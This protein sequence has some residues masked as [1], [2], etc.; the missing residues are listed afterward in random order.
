MILEKL[1]A[2][3]SVCVLAAAIAVVSDRVELPSPTS[4][5]RQPGAQLAAAG[6]SLQNVTGDLR[7][8]FKA[9]SSGNP[10]MVMYALASLGLMGLMLRS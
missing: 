4:Y 1:L 9:F 5:G 2:A 10:A 3:A 7:D 6:A 8:H